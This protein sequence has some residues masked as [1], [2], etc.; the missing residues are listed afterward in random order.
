MLARN[1]SHAARVH[2]AMG[3]G[4]GTLWSLLALG[5]VLVAAVAAFLV[6]RALDVL[7]FIPAD[8]DSFALHVLNLCLFLAA[9]AALGGLALVA[10]RAVLLGRRSVGATPLDGVL[11]LVAGGLIAIA[12]RFTLL[13][14]GYGRFASQGG[15]P[16]LLGA[17]VFLP[18]LVVLVALASLAQRLGPSGAP[19]PRLLII[20]AA[21]MVVLVAASNLPGLGDGL[22]PDSGPLAIAVTL[23]TAYAAAAVALGLRGTPAI[24]DLR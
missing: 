16:E 18:E 1:A 23:S 12:L 10:L 20:A 8:W 11:A 7:Q 13:A 14:W 3:G 22:A 17:T 4:T 19:V 9:W 2:G 6:R 15:D 24:S 5:A 21:A